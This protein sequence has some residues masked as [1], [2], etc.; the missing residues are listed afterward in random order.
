MQPIFFNLMFNLG[1]VYG[2]KVGLKLRLIYYDIKSY[3]KVGVQ[4]PKSRESLSPDD[5]A[6]SH[7]E[8]GTIV[9]I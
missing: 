3:S 1:I 2:A 5:I 4:K 8:H 9:V 7:L 6:K